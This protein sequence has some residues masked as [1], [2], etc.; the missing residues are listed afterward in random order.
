MAISWTVDVN[1]TN[2]DDDRVQVTYTRFDD[3]L[4][5][6]RVYVLNAQYNRAHDRNWNLDAWND[7]AWALYQEEVAE[8]T[9]ESTFIVNWEAD[10]QTDMN[11]R[12][13]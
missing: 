5:E 12:E 11:G 7:T 9:A 3:V 4:D 13:P 6:T 10:M 1:I 2:L 8:E